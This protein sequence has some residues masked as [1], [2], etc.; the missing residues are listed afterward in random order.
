MKPR[1]WRFLLRVLEQGFVSN[2]ADAVSS[3][4]VASPTGAVYCYFGS[5]KIRKLNKNT[6]TKKENRWSN[7]RFLVSYE[8]KRRKAE[9]TISF[10]LCKVVKKK[11]IKTKIKK[12]SKFSILMARV[13]T[14]IRKL[15]HAHFWEAEG[16]RSELFLLLTCPHTTTFTL[17]SIF[18]PWEVS[19]VKIWETIRS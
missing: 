19:S 13:G 1:N 12:R 14:I 16:N 3:R 4:Y 5:D 8:N 15:K 10:L 18:S 7:L 9:M 17:L 2:F 11:I 6:K